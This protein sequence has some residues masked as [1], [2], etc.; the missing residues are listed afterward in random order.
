MRYSFKRSLATSEL[1]QPVVAMKK[2]A[3]S[4][5]FLSLIAWHTAFAQSVSSPQPT[6]KTAVSDP[7]KALRADKDEMAD[8][9]F[10]SSK[11][12][13]KYRNA[14]GFY[15]YFG[16]RTN[17]TFTPLRLVAQYFGNDWLFVEKAWAKADGTRVDIPTASGRMGWER[18]NGSGNIWEWSDYAL[19][20]SAEIEAVTR[21]AFSKTVT[22]RYVGRQYYDDKKLSE[23]QLAALREV[24][25]AYEAATGKPW[26]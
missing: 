15:L 13:P 7:L 9:T 14:N 12:S 17:G 5:V 3:L 16:K 4:F 10:Y 21:I 24:I 25:V 8:I 19:R 26:K 23:K 22:V 1:Q 6:A 18:D 2:Q 20:S 11:T